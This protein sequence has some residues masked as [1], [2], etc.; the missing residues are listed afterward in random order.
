MAVDDN[1][2]LECI[3]GHNPAFQFLDGH[4]QDGIVLLAGSTN[5]PFTGTHWRIH[6][7]GDVWILECLGNVSG[8]RFLDGRTADN[9]VQLAPNIHRPFTGTR[10]RATEQL[11]EQ[12]NRVFALECLGD[13]PGNR[14]LEGRNHDGTVALAANS[15]PDFPGTLWRVGSAPVPIDNP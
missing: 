7:N 13:Q 11:D 2:V 14:F 12:D 1:V 8:N 9:V 4:T 3:G 6:R 15:G 5:P 10:W